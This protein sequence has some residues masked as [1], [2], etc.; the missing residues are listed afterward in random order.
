MAVVDEPLPLGA[1]VDFVPS[2]RLHAM[3][4]VTP[5]SLSVGLVMA[6]PMGGVHPAVVWCRDT[7]HIFDIHALGSNRYTP[8]VTVAASQFLKEGDLV[9]VTVDA[10]RRRIIF[11]VNGSPLAP[12]VSGEATDDATALSKDSSLVYGIPG[13]SVSVHELRAAVWLS[14]VDDAVFVRA[15]ET[16]LPAA[17]GPAPLMLQ[18]SVSGATTASR[19]EA[20]NT[21]GG[22]SA[23]QVDELSTFLSGASSAGKGSVADALSKLAW[24]DDLARVSAVLRE[25][26][27]QQA[28]HSL[29]KGLFGSHFSST[30]T[31][32]VESLH[33]AS[34]GP[35]TLQ[36]TITVPG[37]SAIRVV[38]DKRS[39]LKAK[40]TL[41][42][43]SP[44]LLS[45]ST[46]PVAAGSEVFVVGHADSSEAE[47]IPPAYV[48]E[49]DLDALVSTDILFR[50]AAAAPGAGADDDSACPALEAGDRV[51][52]N[53]TG[54]SWGDQDGGEGSVGVVQSV[55]GK[56]V[57]VKWQQGTSNVYP[58]PDEKGKHHLKP[59]SAPAPIAPCSDGG[60]LVSGNA[61]SISAL[62]SHASKEES[63]AVALGGTAK[64]AVVASPDLLL[65]LM[66][67]TIA[68]ESSTVSLS[69]TW[70]RFRPAEAPVGMESPRVVFSV[71]AVKPGTS[72][73]EFIGHTSVGRATIYNL[74][75]ATKYS[76]GVGASW[77]DG[78]A[79]LDSAPKPATYIS[80]EHTT[81]AFQ[82]VHKVTG[83]G[84]PSSAVK[85][86]SEGTTVVSDG[87]GDSA[88]A[89]LGN[90]AV[91]GGVSEWM[92]MVLEMPANRK[93]AL[94]GYAIPTV[95]GP[96]SFDTGEGLFVMSGQ[97]NVFKNGS[98]QA[99]SFATGLQEGDV[100]TVRYDAEAHSMSFTVNS[101]PCGANITDIPAGTWITPCV[102]IGHGPGVQ[103]ALL[104]MSHTSEMTLD[105]HSASVI[106]AQR[107]ITTTVTPMLQAAGGASTAVTSP[108]L[109][110][111]SPVAAATGAGVASDWGVR[112]AVIPQLDSRVMDQALSSTF[113]ASLP[114]RISKLRAEDAASSGQAS[115][116]KNSAGAAAGEQPDPSMPLAVPAAPALLMRSS[117]VVQESPAVGAPSV[118]SVTDAVTH[119]QDVYTAFIHDV[120]SGWSAAADEELVELI[121]SVSGEN[122]SFISLSSLLTASWPALWAAALSKASDDESKLLRRYRHLASFP[123]SQ[124]EKRFAARFTLLSTFNKL[125][126]GSLAWLDFSRIMVT[127]SLPAALPH[128]SHWIFRVFK[129]D[130]LKPALQRTKGSGSQFTLVLSRPRHYRFMQS[131]KVDTEGRHTL[132][133]QAWQ[134]M[135]DMP[136]SILR[137]HE[138]LFT[139]NFA[140]ERSHDDGGPYREAFAEFC[141]ALQSDSLPLLVRVPNHSARNNTGHNRDC[142]MLS[143]DAS[144]TSALSQLHFLGKLMGMALRNNEYLSLRLA[145]VVW[146]MLTG[147]TPVEADLRDMDAVTHK[148][149]MRIGQDPELTEGAFNSELS[150]E[151]WVTSLS[152]G[153]QVEV[154]P[155]GSSRPLTWA[156]RTEYASAAFII[157]LQQM[158]HQIAAVRA[159]FATIVPVNV[160]ALFSGRQLEELVCGLTGRIDVDLLERMTDFSGWSRSDKEVQW[161]FDVLREAEPHE[162]A[163]VLQFISGR[164]TIG[165]NEATFGRRFKIDRIGGGDGKWP[166]SHSC[167]NVLD[168]PKY[169]TKELLRERILTAS[170]LCK[171]I[172]AD[173]TSTGLANAALEAGWD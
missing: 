72:D 112:M 157:Q 59:A 64:Q 101:A 126:Q 146:R 160:L 150:G 3:R 83:T 11:S 91:R 71:M 54:W 103:I 50:R 163:S 167:Y 80:A 78:S 172:D 170:A 156:H 168:L 158:R 121:D 143:A 125:L 120:T 135:R 84:A 155:G 114:Q 169:S 118:A 30:H 159:G 173:D 61:V 73:L 90:T 17:P 89:A 107:N 113:L 133:G 110:A 48:H 56:W 19:S 14:S 69:L 31:R 40:E 105:A 39:S 148:T 104:S 130:H 140:G 33:P 53:P 49:G 18:R 164:P 76:L 75:S 154:V 36:R 51:Q 44:A 45:S 74:A 115:T 10:P 82:L 6:D 57:R 95:D 81:D 94:G 127:G 141:Q 137:R 62:F 88:G 7:I 97:G 47:T 147:R 124:R 42:V 122:T 93:I 128:A 129:D 4:L 12:I 65:P 134:V 79:A 165:R 27:A 151:T 28:P 60:M 16:A 77:V 13:A 20:G 70:P 38:L 15:T 108:V 138:K 41:T 109:S 99:A 32:T 67:D 66:G 29:L 37:A 145:P 58:C 102:S 123:A 100:V 132:F 85:I 139:A 52:R 34:D 153:R 144:G 21:E 8:A 68:V 161:F 2:V 166:M 35:G 87:V 25:M 63:D 26:Q 171:S 43:G 152:T 149:L 162:V 98:K 136:T 131:G 24:F 5:G 111:A 142:W 9:G 106:A 23:G 119:L 116:G 117:S 1:D 96:A 46:L 86:L 92:C 22:R 55:E